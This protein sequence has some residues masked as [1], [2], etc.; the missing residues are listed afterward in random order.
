MDISTRDYKESDNEE[1]KSII[2]N[3]ENFGEP[4]LKSELQRIALFYQNSDVGRV[5]VAENPIKGTILGYV[6][7]EF[8]W[9]KLIIQSIITHH[10]YLRQGIGKNLINKVF[11]IGQ[12]HPIVNVIRVDTGDFMAY[13]QKFY[14]AN[15]FQICGY[16]SHDLSWYND[17]VHLVYPLEE[18]IPG[19]ND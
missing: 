5:L 6:T 3:G 8:H 15:G 7:I 13:A 9:R 10:E 16:V 19:F 1:L 18:K 4:F 12:N 14:L 11:E 17:Q 2:L